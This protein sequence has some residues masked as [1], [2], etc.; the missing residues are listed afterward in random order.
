ML[1]FSNM[2]YLLADELAGLRASR[3]PLAFVLCCPP[4]RFFVRHRAS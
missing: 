3:F 1:G 4:L 2:V